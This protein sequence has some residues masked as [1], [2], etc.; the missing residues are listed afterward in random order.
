MRKAEYPDNQENSARIKHHILNMVNQIV[1]LLLCS[2]GRLKKDKIWKRN[3]VLLKQEN[4][5][6]IGSGKEMLN[7]A[8]RRILNKFIQFWIITEVA[9]N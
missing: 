7:F 9:R 2:N 1:E 3:D 8:K 6:M 4:K 5:I